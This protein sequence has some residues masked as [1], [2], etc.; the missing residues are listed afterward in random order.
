MKATILVIDDDYF[1]RTLL[2]FVLSDHYEVIAVENG[3]KAMLWLD[4][5]NQP[6]LILSDIDMPRMDGFNFLSLLRKSGYYRHTPL[7]MLT[8]HTYP[9]LEEKC[10]QAG[11]SGYF[12]KPF[13]PTA[14]LEMIRQTL[15][16]QPEVFTFNNTKHA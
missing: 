7:V 14:L 2:N 9:G 1:L 4:Q 6:D 8:G 16:K 15:H 13:N 10:R 3:F 12:T 11:A 5:G